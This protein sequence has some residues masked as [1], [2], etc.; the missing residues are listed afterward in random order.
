MVPFDQIIF[1]GVNEVTRPTSRFRNRSV[2]DQSTEQPES[3]QRATMSDQKDQTVTQTSAV[4]LAS[5]ARLSKSTKKNLR[6]KRQRQMRATISRVDDQANH[7]AVGNTDTTLEAEPES[8]GQIEYRDGDLLQSDTQYI[9]HQ[10]NCMTTRPKGLARSLFRAFPFAD[11][12]SKR[13][14]TGQEDSPGTISVHH[15]KSVG[16]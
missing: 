14:Q 3:Q 10:C 5:D 13:L 8:K 11:V 16:G 2:H 7:T 6:R 1:F 9:C 15:G 4:A 12:Y